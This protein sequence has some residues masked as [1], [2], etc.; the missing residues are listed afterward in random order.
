M[1]EK[2]SITEV[3]I[4]ED[5]KGVILGLTKYPKIAMLEESEIMLKEYIEKYGTPSPNRQLGLS[6]IPLIQSVDG[7]SVGAVLNPQ[8][9]EKDQVVVNYDLDR[10]VT[11]MDIRM[12]V[13]AEIGKVLAATFHT[14]DINQPIG[15]TDS[16]VPIER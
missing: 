15:P 11:K 9:P 7:V 1:I 2:S 3:T 13:I 14:E 6:M 12:D 8:A 16:M 4:F 10:F 5:G